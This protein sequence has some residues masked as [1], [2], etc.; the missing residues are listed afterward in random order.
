TDFNAFGDFNL[1]ARA[2][3][4]HTTEVFRIENRGGPPGQPF[5]VAVED[6]HADGGATMKLVVAEREAP[7]QSRETAVE[8]TIAAF[9]MAH[10]SASGRD[11]KEHLKRVGLRVRDEVFWGLWKDARP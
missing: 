6:G 10:P 7:A 9:R 3:D 2:P 8:E 5:Q 11:G 1:Y 4:E